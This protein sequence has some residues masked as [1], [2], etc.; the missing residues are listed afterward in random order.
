MEKEAKVPLL[1]IVIP[2][3]RSELTIKNVVHDIVD[4]ITKVA[5]YDYEIIL[6]NDGSPDHTFEVIME[7]C[8]NNKK[9]KGINLAQNFGQHSAL[10]AGYR[11][12]RGDIIITMDDD[13]QSPA[14]DIIKLIQPI[15]K[16]EYDVVIGK[17]EEKKHSVFRNVGSK[18][19]EI[20]ARFLINWPRD[21]RSSSFYACKRYVTNEIIK[22]ENPY[23]Y[24]E[25][26]VV[27]VTSNIVNVEVNHKEREIGKSNY[28]LKKLISLWLN[29]FTAFSVRPLRIA[30]VLGGITAI[31]GFI[32][33]FTIIYKKLVNNLVAPG[34]TSIMAVQLIIGGMILCVLGLIGE[35]IGRIYISINNSPQYVIKDQINLLHDKKKTIH[36]EINN[37][38]N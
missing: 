34:W 16:G 26:L 11:H 33:T 29:G 35:Y 9:V 31:T 10:M 27:R 1:S 23:P 24:I 32:Y 7:L 21:L 6:V 28:T 22:Y 4:T 20:M 2:C 30:T 3:Y 19:N 15:I 37:E 13:G 25:G 17:Y 14:K 8:K 18:L 12:V 36:G 5:L 38:E